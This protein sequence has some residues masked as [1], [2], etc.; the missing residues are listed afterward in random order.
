[1]P[2]TTS[3]F[4]DSPQPFAATSDSSASPHRTRSYRL[5]R[6][7]VLTNRQWAED[8]ADR[9]AA[10]YGDHVRDALAAWRQDRGEADP[11]M[12][13][14]LPLI[15]E[16][17]PVGVLSNSTDALHAD[18]AHHGITFD[19][20]MPS[21]DLGVDKPSPHAYRLAAERM[22]TA[23]G[24]L[25]YFDDEP[26]FVRSA[27]AAGLQAHLFMSATDVQQHLGR[28]CVKVRT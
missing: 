11:D 7:G 19:H 15:R 8:V 24:D 6:V 3:P 5:A 13:R 20:V 12:L 23:P 10:D 22:A 1:M 18:L 21:A 14:L 2:A 25:L 17:F 27:A 16:Q 26:T 4:S 9:L 28:C